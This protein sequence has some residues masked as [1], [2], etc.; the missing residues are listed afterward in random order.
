VKSF[1]QYINESARDFFIESLADKIINDLKKSTKSKNYSHIREY[2]YYEPIAFDLRLK[3]RWDDSSDFSRDLHFRDLEWEKHNFSNLGYAINA[4]AKFNDTD[5][6]IPEIDL[7]IVINSTNSRVYELIRSRLI[8][9]LAHEIRHTRQIGLN[10]E[11]FMGR[12][13]TDGERESA[14]QNYKYFL[15]PE[16]LDSMIEDKYL[17]AKHENRPVDDI[18][19]QYL[20]PFVK[21]GFMTSS[22]FK[23]VHSIWIK[24]AI[25]L[26]PDAIF[27]KKAQ[28]II[29]SI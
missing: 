26:F 24:R 1:I 14:Q 17:Q 4:I 15:L 10:K 6:R 8:G 11:P 2:E 23:K 25:E 7:F 13:S 28:K 19:S 22:E 27:S 3:A 20:Y 29:D 9:I 5:F 12:V 21:D 18:I 16:E